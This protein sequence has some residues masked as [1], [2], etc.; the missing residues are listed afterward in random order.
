MSNKLLA[1]LVTAA[2]ITPL[3]AICIIGPVVLGSVAASVFAWLGGFDPVTTTSLAVILAI[4]IYGLFR[5]RRSRFGVVD[6][7][8]IDTRRRRY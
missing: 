4:L 2:V 1:G 5:R 6:G 7:R 3:C 8:A